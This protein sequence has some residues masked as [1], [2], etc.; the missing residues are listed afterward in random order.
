MVHSSSSCKHNTMHV[1][2]PMQCKERCAFCAVGYLSTYTVIY[3][4]QITSQP[5]T[6]IV[7]MTL[8]PDGEDVPNDFP[9]ALLLATL[10]VYEFT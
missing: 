7:P 10:F 5:T 6:G 3:A 9:A 1:K 8:E 2:L 4:V